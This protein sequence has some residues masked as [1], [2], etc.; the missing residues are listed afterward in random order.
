MGFGFRYHVLQIHIDKTASNRNKIK[1]ELAVLLTEFNI[2]EYEFS[3]VSKEI[4]HMKKC[5][6]AIYNIPMKRVTLGCFAKSEKHYYALT[7][8]H[9]SDDPE[10]T[11]VIISKTREVLGHITA[12]SA[13]KDIAAIELAPAVQAQCETALRDEIDRP[14]TIPCP[15]WFGETISAPLDVYIIGAES[16][17]GIGKLVSFEYHYGGLSQFLLIEDRISRDFCRQET[18]EQ[19][20]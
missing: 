17:P 10:S 1:R 19:L 6:E 3:F 20:L 14:L 18:V 13:Q 5:G 11:A 9:I 12:F 4:A 2:T 16:R 8:K 7:C 15:T